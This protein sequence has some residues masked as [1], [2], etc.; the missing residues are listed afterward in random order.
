MGVDTPSVLARLPH[1]LLCPS[2][3]MQARHMYVHTHVHTY[4]QTR[5]LTHTY[6]ICLKSVVSP[7]C[8]VL[9]K[10]HDHTT[11]VSVIET[12]ALYSDQGEEKYDFFFFGENK[13]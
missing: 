2:P 11:C 12:Q 8:P 6:M 1:V 10:T 9:I 3:R 5:A 4:S 13:V 7:R